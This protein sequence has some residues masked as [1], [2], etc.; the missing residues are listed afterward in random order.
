MLCCRLGCVEVIYVT[1][2]HLR[3]VMEVEQPDVAMHSFIIRIWLE[4]TV[5]EAGKAS[6]RGHITHIPSNRRQHIE[7]LD[8]VKQFIAPYLQSMGVNSGK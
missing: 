3:M 1:P 5:I 4:E 6:W 2:N 8:A 7:N